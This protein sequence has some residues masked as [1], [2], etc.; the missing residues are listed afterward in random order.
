[1][2]KHAYVNRGVCVDVIHSLFWDDVG[3]HFSASLIVL[4]PRRTSLVSPIL[5]PDQCFD[6]SLFC[7]EDIKENRFSTIYDSQN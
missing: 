5:K 3:A 2:N 4:L 7:S 6:Y 1:M